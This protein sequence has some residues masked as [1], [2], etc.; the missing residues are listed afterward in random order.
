MIFFIAG[1][2]LYSLRPSASQQKEGGFYLGPAPGADRA[3][4][5]SRLAPHRPRSTIYD[6]PFSPF[7][8]RYFIP[9]FTLRDRR[10]TSGHCVSDRGAVTVHIRSAP[11]PRTTAPPH[12]D[13]HP[14]LLFFYKRPP[15]DARKN[16]RPGG[17]ITAVP[18]H[19]AGINT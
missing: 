2:Y 16:S 14:T 7:L 8:S 15:R 3:N 1:I 12:S 17:E 5:R 19:Y 13:T 11:D 6:D 4:D 18:F 9:G 10:R